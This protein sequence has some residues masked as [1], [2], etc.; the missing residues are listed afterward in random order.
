MGF[1]APEI[2]VQG[3]AYKGEKIDVFSFGVILFMLYAG[4]TPFG[5]AHKSDKFYNLFI[6]DKTNYWTQV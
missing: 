5:E 1:A 6:S 4:I 2:Y 3:K